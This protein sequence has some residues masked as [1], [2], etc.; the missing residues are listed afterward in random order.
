MRVVRQVVHANDPGESILLRPLPPEESQQTA[1]QN[2]RSYLQVV[3]QAIHYN[4]YRQEVLQRKVQ[5]QRER[6]QA[7]QSDAGTEAV[8][9]V[10]L[11]FCSDHRPPRL[12][13]R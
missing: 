8:Q 4:V 12:L 9:V 13:L 11:V 2:V 6:R 10:R 5:E 3:W 1:I 7:E